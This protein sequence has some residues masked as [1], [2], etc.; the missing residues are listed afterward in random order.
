L[1]YYGRRF[2]DPNLQ[3]WVNRDPIQEYGGYNLY[4][5]AFNS[6]VNFLDPYG[7]C[8]TAAEEGAGAEGDVAESGLAE[9]AAGEGAAGIGL[10]DLGPIAVAGAV[11]WGVGT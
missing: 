11:G 4:A 6:A 3:R 10:A 8:P 5:F 2:Y 1:Y 9:G 7:A